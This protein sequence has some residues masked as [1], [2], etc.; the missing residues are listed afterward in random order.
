VEHLQREGFD[1]GRFL[2][3][4][5]IPRRALDDAAVR[6]PQSR[7][8]GLWRAAI[9]ATGDPAIALR[10]STRVKPS[11]LGVIG[12]LASASESPRNAFE[13]VR[14]LTPLLWEDFACDLECDEE[15]AFIH[16][17]PLRSARVNRF[18][19]EYA[20]GLTV[21]MSRAVAAAGSEPVEARFSYPAPDY[22]DAYERILG[23]PVV[24]DA[25]RDGVVFPISA[26]D[27]S[28]PSADAAL[29]ELLERY[30]ADQ[31]ARILANAPLAQRIR[32]HV[33]SA[34]PSGQ[35]SSDGVAARFS[36]STRTLRRRLQDEG[37]SYQE[38][39][40]D[41]RAE[42]ARQY[43]TRDGLGIEETSFLLGFSDPS[44]FGKAFRRWTGRTPADLVRAEASWVGGA[45]HGRNR[46]AR[47]P[48][49]TGSQWRPA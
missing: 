2:D 42:R 21:A 37:T 6:L 7:F 31:L 39:L 43:L 34:L 13:I 9:D 26:I 27:C 18:T 49:R 20:I 47:G 38:I 36:M 33:V 25:E 8:E 3:A 32:A 30:A 48:D 40:D 41:V 5:G 45:R 17:R 1:P 16:C 19:M 46:R 44:A 15:L 24:F 10:V 11:T 35:L 4:A 29:R 28:N 12:Y 23:L 14:R 22:G